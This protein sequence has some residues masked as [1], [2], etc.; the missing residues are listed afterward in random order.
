MSTSSVEGIYRKAEVIADHLRSSIVGGEYERGDRLPTRQVLCERYGVSNVTVQRAFDRLAGEGFI[1]SVERQGTFVAEDSPHLT[2]YALLFPGRPG[3]GMRNQFFMALAREAEDFSEESNFELHYG[4]EGHTGVERYRALLED[5]RN[6]RLA[7]V[8]FA[9]PPLALKNS[10]IV[11]RPGIPRAAFM[12]ASPA[13]DLPAV[14][15]DHEEF[16]RKL[17]AEVENSGRLRVGAIASS[18]QGVKFAQKLQRVL[19]E[20]GVPI[21]PDWFQAASLSEPQWAIPL[22]RLLMNGEGNERPESPC[23]TSETP[24]PGL[25]KARKNGHSPRSARLQKN[26]RIHIQGR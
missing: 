20:A 9:S 26:R 10:P 15:I 13:L 24:L 2:R 6:Q 19:R 7:G 12:T 21:E 17:V 16:L 22:T 4:F 14:T 5:V 18:R 11:E 1:V 8:I 25:P 3:E 23:A